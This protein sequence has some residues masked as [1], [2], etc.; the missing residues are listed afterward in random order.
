MAFLAVVVLFLNLLRVRWRRSGRPLLEALA[1]DVDR[2]YASLWHRWS[3]G[4]APLSAHGPAILVANHTCSADPTFLLAGSPR[5]FGFLTSRDHYNLHPL[6]R[7]LLDWL[8]CVPVTRNG[9]DASAAREALRRLA[10]GK[11]LCVFPEGNLSGVGRGRLRAAKHGAAFLALASRAPVFPV[12]IAGGPR[13]HKLLQ[14]WLW[15]CGRA[16]RVHYGQPVD[17]S[18]YYHRPRT[19]KLLAE[20]TELL[21]QQVAALAPRRKTA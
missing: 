21:M 1:L 19:R 17:L 13:T 8:G 18:A 4:P 12:Y 3:G 9:Q 20:V 11:A 7:W 10:Q 5:L 14:A 6:S 15:P 2:L 16:V